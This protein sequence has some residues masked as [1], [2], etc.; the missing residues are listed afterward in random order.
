MSQVL[1]NGLN[2][3][4]LETAV[5]AGIK[6]FEGAV[7]TW[8]IPYFGAQWQSS[9]QH[10]TV[11]VRK[12]NDFFLMRLTECAVTRWYF[13]NVGLAIGV[14]GICVTSLLGAS[15]SHLYWVWL[16][17]WLGWYGQYFHQFC[18]SIQNLLLLTCEPIHVFWE[19]AVI[20][21]GGP[22]SVTWVVYVKQLYL[23]L[24][25]SSLSFPLV[26][27]HVWPHPKSWG[28]CPSCPM[29]LAPSA[30]MGLGRTC[31]QNFVGIASTLILFNHFSPS[32][33]VPAQ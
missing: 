6:S 16:K 23:F 28:I 19:K 15:V 31:F 2:I 30:F 9:V 17:T 11:W 29:V 20:L 10:V 4:Q 5:G 24:F 8:Q 13:Y 14:K 3:I 32:F 21:I 12:R 18:C 22:D 1:D 26:S 27:L 7:G 25:N 33:V